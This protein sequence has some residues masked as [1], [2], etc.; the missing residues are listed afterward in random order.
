[1]HVKAAHGITEWIKCRQKVYEE[2]GEVKCQKCSFAIQ[3]SSHQPRTC[4]LNQQAVK[5]FEVSSRKKSN[6]LFHLKYLKC[7]I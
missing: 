6:K 5:K 7:N 3:K 2:L 1:M 4:Q